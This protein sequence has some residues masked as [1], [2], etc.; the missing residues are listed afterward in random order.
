M[1]IQVRFQIDI[2]Q[3][4]LYH[5]FLREHYEHRIRTQMDRMGNHTKM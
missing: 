5:Y 3:T 2:S 4:S 1:T